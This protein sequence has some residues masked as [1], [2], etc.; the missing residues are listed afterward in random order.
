MIKKNIQQP[1]N[2]AWNRPT[3]EDGKSIWDKWVKETIQMYNVHPMC[4]KINLK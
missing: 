1:L 4:D 3:D 2:S